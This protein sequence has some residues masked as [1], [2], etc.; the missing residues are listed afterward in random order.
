MTDC[1]LPGISGSELGR[2]LSLRYQAMRV[3]YMS[4]YLDPAA[5][6]DDGVEPGEVFLSKPFTI[7]TLLK[8][9]GQVLDTAA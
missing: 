2:R 7:D 9:L 4:G 5:L 3:I 1:V 8:K 6:K